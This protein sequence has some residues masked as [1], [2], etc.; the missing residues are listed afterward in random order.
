MTNYF[1]PEYISTQIYSKSNVARAY[2]CDERTNKYIVLSGK[3]CILWKHIL[4]ILDSEK[5]LCLKKHNEKFLNLF[6]NLN[7]INEVIKTNPT[8]V[9]IEDEKNISESYYFEEEMR[10]WLY[11]NDYM[12]KGTLRKNFKLSRIVKNVRCFYRI[13]I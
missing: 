11:K 8:L 6:L 13:A 2:I 4:S 12:K 9:S 5:T 10:H 1:I 7:I 3:A